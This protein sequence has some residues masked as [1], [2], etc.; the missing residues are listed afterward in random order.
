MFKNEKSCISSD[1][2]LIPQREITFHMCLMKQMLGGWEGDLQEKWSTD[3]EH[4]GMLSKLS[5]ICKLHIQ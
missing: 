4:T 2:L 3:L 1:T 5:M